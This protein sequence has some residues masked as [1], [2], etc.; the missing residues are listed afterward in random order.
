[1]NGNGAVF[2]IRQEKR[3]ANRVC[4]AR[5]YGHYYERGLLSLMLHVGF[6]LIVFGG[7]WGWGCGGPIC[8]VMVILGSRLFT[9]TSLFACPFSP[10]GFGGR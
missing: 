4:V 8:L 10:R 1:M 7:I 6:V 2:G 9:V 3:D 5:H